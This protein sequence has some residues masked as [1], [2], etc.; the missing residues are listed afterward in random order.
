[1]V[2]VEWW[3]NTRETVSDDLPAWPAASP[4]AGAKLDPGP[5]KRRQCRLASAPHAERGR[6]RSPPTRG[7]AQESERGGPGASRSRPMTRTRPAL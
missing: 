1:M 7:G 5:G 4:S 2:R 6:K 3:R